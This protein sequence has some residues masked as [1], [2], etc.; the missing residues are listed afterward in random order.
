MPESMI[1]CMKCKLVE[2]YGHGRYCGLTGKAISRYPKNGDCENF[3]G[4][5]DETDTTGDTG[6]TVAAKKT[7]AIHARR[8][9]NDV[10]PV[11][12]GQSSFPFFGQTEVTG[13]V[14]TI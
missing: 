6:E 9:S 2:V 14:R 11:R 5:R 10:R 8:K 4:D 12:K 3:I 1:L 7:S 13:K